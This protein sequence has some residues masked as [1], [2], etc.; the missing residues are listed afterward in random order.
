MAGPGDSGGRAAAKGLLAYFT[1]HA[2]AANLVFVLCIAAGLAALPRMRAQYFPDVV[3]Q[4]I[5][6]SVAWDGA[7]AED[8]DRAIVQLV[9]PGLIG[10]EGVQDVT[11]TAREGRAGI[12]L[13]FEPG[14]DMNRAQGDV[15]AALAAAGAL[16]EGADDPTVTLGAWRDRVTDV[17]ISGPVGYDQLTRLADDFLVRLHRAGVTRASIQGI[18]AP[19]LTV[20]VSAAALL[21]YDLTLSQIAERIAAEVDPD[22]AG[23]IGGGAARLRTGSEK[24][25]PEA[26]RAIALRSDADGGALMLG[27]VAV[28][29]QEAGNAVLGYY[30]GGNPAVLLRAERSA[31]GDAIAI[32]KSVESTAAEM[33][34]TLPAGVTIDLIRSRSEEIEARL[35]IL[36]GNGL[37]GLGL[38]VTL[39]FLFLNART[40]FWVAAGIPVAMLAAAAIMY[41]VGITLNM[42]SLFALILTLGIVV[43]DAIVVGEHAD[44]RART[45]GEPA[46]I[47]AENAVRRMA[48]PVFSSTITTVIAFLGLMAISGRFG[49]LI[50]D[51][52]FTVSVVLLASLIESFLIL[53]NHMAHALSRIGRGRWYDAPSR[54]MNRGLGWVRDRLVRPLTRAVIVA[55]YPVI[56]GAVALL[57]WEGSLFLRGDVAWRFFNSPEQPV[58]TG[59]FAMLPGAT[60]ED[61]RRVM[62]ALQASTDAVA[63]TFRDGQGG[64]NPLRFVLAQIGANS[65][66]Y[67]ASSDTKEPEQLGS[68]SIELSDPD[69]RSW[70]ASDFVTALQKAAP[71]DPML[72]ELSFRGWHSGPGGDAIDVQLYGAGAGEL[73]RAAEALKRGLERFPEVSGLED[74]MPYD[75]DELLLDLTPQ[76]RALGFTVEALGRELRNRLSGIEAATF[77]DGT[78]TAAIRVELPASEL[79]ADFLDR[80]QLRTATGSYV[81]L[82][83]IVSVSH[84]SGFST[85]RRE[86]GQRVITVTGALD[87]GDPARAAAITSA[88]EREILPAI[89][90]DHGVGFAL[91]GLHEQEDRFLSDAL[92]GLAGALMG[93]FAVLAWIFASWTRPVVVMSV[94]P[95]SLIGAIHGHWI[96][97]I[98]MSMFSVVGL[99]GMSGIIINDAI[100]LVSTVDEYAPGRNFR[101]AV[102]DAVADRLRPVMLTTVTTV[103]GLAPLLYESSRQAQFLKPTVITLCY[104]LGFG[105]VL[106]LL[107]VPALLVVQQDLRRQFAALG[108][109][110]RIAA[111]RP[112]LALGALATLLGFAVFLWPVMADGAPPLAGFLRYIASVAAALLLIAMA[113][114]V[115]IR[116]RQPRSHP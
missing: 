49:D 26:L 51:I 96:W 57:A 42:M 10:I 84:R 50:A 115:L 76:G 7:G 108:R 9:E 116:R 72:E 113:G 45:L 12:N 37:M 88:L 75:K 48:A 1:R 86:N 30:S 69:L 14:W 78:R 34:A 24:R 36:L 102:V 83:D 22:P 85:I 19:D 6:V 70:T 67:L 95:L 18:G 15:E 53:P 3:V 91:A 103:F 99:I 27:D 58:I 5:D 65:W 29:R 111:L 38:V 77:P 92:V 13:E 47:A 94:I 21:R 55:R 44:Y 71:R 4:E 32:Q 31:E 8:V 2:T 100:V 20:E 59:N 68:I 107:V 16:P 66:P 89:A 35:D 39:L 106:V 81:P 46:V 56:A 25:S 82:G 101:A 63:E 40:A 43:D 33:R 41:S 93:I 79:T 52:P 110:A 54:V 64:A 80:T 97:D 105:M 74:T 62:A 109:A 90:A 17:V 60:I 87:E 28:V 98:P 104:G 23:E 114:A 73:K 11:S 61:T 112:Y